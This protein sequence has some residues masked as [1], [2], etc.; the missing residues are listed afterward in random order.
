VWDDEDT[1]GSTWG[2]TAENPVETFRGAGSVINEL[3][4]ILSMNGSLLPNLSPMGQG[5]INGVSAAVGAGA[6]A[7]TVARS[8]RRLLPSYACRSPLNQGFSWR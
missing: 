1:E 5:A 4:T 7:E 8:L 6:G 2:S 3:A